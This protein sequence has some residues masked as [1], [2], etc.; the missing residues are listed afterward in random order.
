MLSP[1][2]RAEIDA[3]KTQLDGLRPWPKTVAD[4][5]WKTM[6]LEWIHNSN[7]LEGNSFTFDQ[8][9]LLLEE[10]GTI[11]GKSLREH[12]E[13][14]NHRRAIDYIETIIRRHRPID[15]H[16]VRQIHYLLFVD[17]DDEE[18]GRYRRSPVIAKV[19]YL[20][21]RPSQIRSRLRD[22]L[23]WL[24]KES[25]LLHPVERA[26]IAHDKLICIHPFA[27]GNALTA[28]CLMNLLLLRQGYPPG[29]ILKAHARVYEGALA[30]AHGGDLDPLVRLVGE[31]VDRCLS[32]YLKAL[33]SAEEEET[34]TEEVA[35]DSQPTG[36][37]EGEDV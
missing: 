1:R 14:T 35:Q 11:G 7:A 21:T 2:L 24:R 31:V 23:I 19:D 12:L 25:R 17:I 37:E 22:L 15:G 32:V 3:K 10:G 30:E 8:T 9:K 5:L 6:T 29:I 4:E 36:T 16:S 13:V 28:R 33:T 26:A 18:A 20:P 34:I 27:E